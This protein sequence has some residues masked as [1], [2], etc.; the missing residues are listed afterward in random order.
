MSLSNR[1]QPRKTDVEIDL[2]LPFV[3]LLLTLVGIVLIFSADHAQNINSHL[4]K[5]IWFAVVGLILFILAALVSPRY[6]YALAYIIYI[7]AIIG[8]LMV[9]VAGFVGLGARRWISLG[10]INF[11]PSEPAKIACI[12][13][14]ARLLSYR[15]GPTAPW[16]ML[17]LSIL[18]II[19]VTA[20]VLFQ[21]DLGTSTVF[22][23]ITAAMLAWFGLPLKFFLLI[24]LPVA[25]LFVIV[26]P[27]LVIPAVLVGLLWLWKS[28]IRL[29]WIVIIA[30]LCI[31]AIFTAPVA[32]NQLEP[33]QQK[34]LTTFLNPTA[35]PLGAGYQIIQSKVAIGS[36]GVV[37]QGFLKG[38]QTQLRFLPQQHTDFIFALAGEEFG[39][40]MTSFLIILFGL[41]VLFG[42][43]IA[44]R[45]K[46][47][48]MSLVVVGIVTMIAYHAFVNIGMVIG[49]LPVTGLPLPFLSYGGSFLLTCLLGAGMIQSVSLHRK[50]Y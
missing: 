39:F 3:V 44:S 2:K 27:W 36:G 12:L 19:P 22:P 41:I 8:L 11:Q 7:I 25:S 20:L 6:Y 21:P 49:V 24:L 34:R 29:G 43:N 40:L 26:N 30:I 14:V 18:I 46:N 13:A 33:Y 23:V 50:D 47:Q 45:T 42:I 31:T 48:F 17:G 37:G 16:K 5:Q 15:H 1:K 32:W 4:N 28:G 9:P 38:T 35:D 10:G